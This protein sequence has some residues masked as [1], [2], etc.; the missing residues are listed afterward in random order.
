MSYLISVIIPTYNRLPILKL[1]LQM[2]EQQEDFGGDFE[3]IVVDDGSNDETWSYLSEYKASKFTFSAYHQSNQGAAKARN[4][5]LHHAIGKYIVIVGDDIIPSKNFLL[6]HYQAHQSSSDTVAILGKTV[7]H[8]ELNVN[9]VMKHIDGVGAQQ[10]SYYYMKD[11]MKLDFRHFYTSNISLLR[12]AIMK[13]DKL[14]DTDF[15]LTAYEDVELGYR[16]IGNEE[17]IIYCHD[18]LGYHHHNYILKGFC[19]RQYRAGRMACVLKS[20]HPDVAEKIG[21]SGLKSILESVNRKK[22]PVKEK[23]L[24]KWE[25]LIIETFEQYTNLSYDYIDDIYLGIFQYFCFKGMLEGECYQD[26]C[27]KAL[28]SIIDIYLSSPIK[29]FINHEKH[30]LNKKTL[31]E[32]NKMLSYTSKYS[33][34]STMSYRFKRIK[35][36]LKPIKTKIKPLYLH[37]KKIKNKIT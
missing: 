21:F 19:Q 10:F 6:K 9:N 13:L 37:I 30:N 27:N 32:L 4:T 2:Y 33:N 16:M 36:F 17:S 25:N 11:K 3:V 23:V 24:Q 20:K 28:L 31:D 22:S 5:A 14:F 35:L 34:K 29:Q 26:E 7:W 1:T 15:D 18:I 8:P 12:S